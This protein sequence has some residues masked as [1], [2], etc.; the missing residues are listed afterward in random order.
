MTDPT[1]NVYSPQRLR[2]VLIL[3]SLV[4]LPVVVGC[5][6]LIYYYLRFSVLVER[7][8]RGERW[9]VP[10][11]LYA[12]PL[13]LREGLPL[14]ARGLVKSL[15][16]LK[17]EQKAGGAPGPGEFVA[18]EKTVTFNP[19]PIPGA[20]REPLIVAFEKDRLKDMKG[21]GTKK[22]YPEQ[23]LEPELITYLFDESREKRRLVRY[24]ELPD[25]L[26]KAVLA[27]EDRRF[28]SHPGL[29]PFRIVGAALRNVRAES[30]IQ[31]GS[32]ITQQLCKNFFL[33]PER[34]VRRKVQEAI[35]AFVLERRAE[36]KDILELYLNEVYLGQAG[37]FS[38]NGVGEAARMYFHKDVANLTLPEAALIAGMI[39]SPN[40]YNPY[41]HPQRAGERRNQVIRAMNEAGFIDAAKMEEALAQTLKVESTAFDSTEAPYFVDLVRSQIAQRYDAKDL[42]T[43]NLSILTTLDLQ[44]QAVGQDA[45]ENGLQAVQKLVKAKNHG[46]VQGCLIALEPASGHVVALV[47]G[48]SYGASQYNRVIQARRQPGSTFKPFVYLTAFEATFEDPALP[49]ITPATVVEDAPQVFF[50]EDKEYIPQNYEDKYFGNVTLRKALAKSLNVAT[51]KVAEM[52]GYGR[53]ADLWSNKLGIGAPIKPYPAVALGSFEATPY[54]MATAYNILANGGL[55]VEPVTVLRVTDEKNRTLEQHRPPPPQRVVHEE[56]A[57]LVTNMLRAVLNEGTA[58]AARA[59]GF[60]ADAA[61]K[62]GTT[63]DLRDAWFAGYTPDLL[64]VVWVGFDDNTPIGLSGARAALPIWVDF[65]KGALAGTKPRP[66]PVPSE[67]VV[68]VDIDKD[69]GLLATPYCPTV[70]SEAFIAGTEPMER[71]RHH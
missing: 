20:A 7:R 22:R 67:N 8:L 66:F 63:N 71:C 3:L 39:Q 6:T 38:I 14:S 54:E 44:L 32:T 41:R 45:L 40:P 25:P 11:R 64:C 49:P 5:S 13:V 26:I 23:G 62:T 17:Y 35:L 34:T 57:F 69:T 37:S 46:P 58:A 50:F 33:T 42:T 15:N 4:T 12:R 9:M 56:S 55:K 19:R 36:K 31:G 10:S 51:V 59:W 61:G 70:V 68:F 65:M 27:I 2:L 43:Q 1:R 47:G 29:D 18:G 16:G 30:Y 52:V 48:R 60:S 21:L 53:V 24:E 28:F